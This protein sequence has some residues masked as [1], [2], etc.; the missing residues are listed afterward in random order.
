MPADPQRLTPWFD[1]SVKPERVG[2]YQRDYGDSAL[3]GDL[4]DYWDGKVWR[5]GFGQELS[6]PVRDLS[7]SMNQFRRWR[8]LTE[9]AK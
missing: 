4:P 6:R 3:F 9:Q 8:G 7:K 5:T 1:G 2:W